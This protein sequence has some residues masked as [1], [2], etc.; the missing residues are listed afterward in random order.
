MIITIR[1][2]DLLRFITHADSVGR[3]GY[4]VRVRLF[5]CLSVC[6]TVCPEH[7]S[8]ANDLKVFKLGIRNDLGIS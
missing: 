2:F 8:K 7:N 6:L 5:V 1:L 4:A 3:C